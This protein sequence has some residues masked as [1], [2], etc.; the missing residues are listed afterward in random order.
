MRLKDYEQPPAWKLLPVALALAPIIAA[1]DVYYRIRS[2]V[3]LHDAVA[4]AAET[5]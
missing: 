2:G 4:E 1:V 5:L 3:W